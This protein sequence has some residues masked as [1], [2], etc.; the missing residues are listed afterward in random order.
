MNIRKALPRDAA[1]IAEVQKD[2]WLT[3]YVNEEKGVTVASIEARF[4]DMLDRTARWN[5]TICLS[6][7]IERGVWVAEF[8]E[9]I[10]GFTAPRLDSEGIARVGAL[11]VHHE[12]RRQH[13]GTDLLQ[14]V[15]H[16]YKGTPIF[17]D[18]V[19]YN[20]PAIAFYKKHG[21]VFTGKSTEK[22]G[23]NLLEMCYHDRQETA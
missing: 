23:M 13:V 19:D 10:L 21:F 4:A 2:G 8:K 17:L 14:E 16:L 15:F 7:F 22:F 20:A 3:A 12:A 11:Y 5:A 1:G 18:V 6:D 9:R